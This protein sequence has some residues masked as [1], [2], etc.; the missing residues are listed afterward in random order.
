MAEI[1]PYDEKIEFKDKIPLLTNINEY[2]D[3]F[4]KHPAYVLGREVL[5]T[6][7]RTDFGT[8]EHNN[9][10]ATRD[11]LNEEIKEANKKT[12]ETMHAQGYDPAVY[13]AEQMMLDLAAQ[14]TPVQKTSTVPKL[15]P[16][17]TGKQGR[18]PT[19]KP[20]QV[21]W[22][23]LDMNKM[24]KILGRM[25]VSKNTME[26]KKKRSNLLIYQC[27]NMMRTSRTPKTLNNYYICS[28]CSMVKT[29]IPMKG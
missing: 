22:G 3:E 4:D 10:V 15:V 21:K 17:T 25:K 23:F 8:D 2:D 14:I 19:S 11:K 28:S 1:P 27:E 9:A 16:L 12:Y 20:I 24:L 18:A 6:L 29:L 5:E 13:S 7:S 26:F